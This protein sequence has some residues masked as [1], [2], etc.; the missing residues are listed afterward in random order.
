MGFPLLAQRLLPAFLVGMILAGIF[1]AT[2]STADSQVLTCSAAITQDIN[3]KWKENL[4]A[5]HI[6]TLLVMIAA[7][8]TAIYGSSNVFILAIR[9]YSALGAVLMPLVLL[10][11]YGVDVGTRTT[12]VMMLT[13]FC[14][15]IIWADVLGLNTS[16][17][18]I[19]PGVL[20]SLMVF[21]TSRLFRSRLKETCT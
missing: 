5:S 1:A 12:T 16:V 4:R 11:C 18:E 15:I 20:M 9:A 10:K 3:V 6:T 2:I 21:G 7:A 8:L 17:N 13:S 14:T 19:F